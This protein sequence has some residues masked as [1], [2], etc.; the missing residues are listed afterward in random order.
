MQSSFVITDGTNFLRLEKG[1]FIKTDNICY[2]DRYDQVRRAIKVYGNSIRNELKYS[3]YI[4]RIDGNELIP[5]NQPLRK[6]GTE[7]QSSEITEYDRPPENK[8]VVP[9]PTA[10]PQPILKPETRENK[11]KRTVKTPIRWESTD[12]YKQSIQIWLDIIKPLENLKDKVIIRQ[13]ELK[14]KLAKI[15]DIYQDLE[16]YTEGYR[17][18]AASACNLNTL[19]RRVRLKRRAC[20]DELKLMDAMIEYFK[21]GNIDRLTEKVNIIKNQVY[22]PRALTELF[23]THD[24]TEVAKEIERL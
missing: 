20:K 9:I 4:A 19:K 14:D 8:S 23:R 22:S 21:Y 11:I 15:A 10:A 17:L 5:I 3:F 1:K 18:D 13:K 7:A 24:M 12:E 2:A 6:P 16:H